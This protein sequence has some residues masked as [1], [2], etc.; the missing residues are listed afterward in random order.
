MTLE[1]WQSV[2]F[3]LYKVSWGAGRGR[4]EA[5]GTLESHEDTTDEIQGVQN[6]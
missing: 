5:A 1:S 2:N 4:V 3:F 6:K